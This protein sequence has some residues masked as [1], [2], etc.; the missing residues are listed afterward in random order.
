MR[1]STIVGLVLIISLLLLVIGLANAVDYFP[2]TTT[3]NKAG[4]WTNTPTVCLD[5]PPDKFLALKATKSWELAFREHLQTNIYDYTI[6]IINGWDDRCDILM[7]FE[8]PSD[9]W[10]GTSHL[11]AI[12]CWKFDDDRFCRGAVNPESKNWYRALVHEL[13]HAWGIGHRN[14]FTEEGFAYLVM[15]NDIMISTGNNFEHITTESIDAI[16]F[17]YNHNGW[18]GAFVTHYTVPHD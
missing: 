11:G 1:V 7:T 17:I 13:G 12:A 2:N 3:L 5:N 4:G 16:N 15:Q 8:D 18:N 6:F 14:T 9:L 10:N